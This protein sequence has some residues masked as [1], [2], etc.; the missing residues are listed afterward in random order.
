[1]VYNPLKEKD[2]KKID[3]EYEEI[4]KNLIKQEKGN[5]SKPYIMKQL[6][7]KPNLRKVD[8]GTEEYQ[9]IMSQVRVVQSPEK[10][11]VVMGTNGKLGHK[12]V[13]EACGSSEYFFE[14]GC[15]H[16]KC[17]QCGEIEGGGC[18]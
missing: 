6:R 18:G 13:C 8:V 14:A 3:E 16:P 11:L 12:F 5:Y 15:N 4:K 7:S 1:M 10:E 2:S 9:N 17:S